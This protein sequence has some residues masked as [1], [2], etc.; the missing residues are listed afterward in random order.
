MKNKEIGNYLIWVA[1]NIIVLLALGKVEFGYRDFYPFG[2]FGDINDYD[3]S[4]FLIYTVVP[5]LLILAIKLRN[6]PENKTSS[7]KQIDETN[8]PS[9]T[10]KNNNS[11]G[12]IEKVNTNNELVIGSNNMLDE[13][14]K[15]T[16]QTWYT[17]NAW[18]IICIIALLFF[19]MCGVITQS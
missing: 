13:D 9:N 16:P 4:E 17:R 2:G 3:L 5:L 15:E 12:V 19:K 1:V 18:W 8:T 10:A 7:E 14:D 11:E 6:S